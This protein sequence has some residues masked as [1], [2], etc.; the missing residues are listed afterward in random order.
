MKQ[1]GLLLWQGQAFLLCPTNFASG[2][3]NHNYLNIWLLSISDDKC[4]KAIK[5]LVDIRIM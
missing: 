3:H 5:L 2:K 4:S 1:V